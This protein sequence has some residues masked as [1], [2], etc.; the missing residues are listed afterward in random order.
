MA[1]NESLNVRKDC[2]GIGSLNENVGKD[3]LLEYFHSE[4]NAVENPVNIADVKEGAS[5]FC[6]TC[7][8]SFSFKSDNGHLILEAFS[9]EEL[10]NLLLEFQSFTFDV[11]HLYL[12]SLLDEKTQDKMQPK[13]ELSIFMKDEGAE[14]NNQFADLPAE[15][16]GTTLL[17]PETELLISMKK[18]NDSLC[19]QTNNQHM[20]RLSEFD[21]EIYNY[22]K[23]KVHEEEFLF[24]FEN[25]EI[26][27]QHVNCP[28]EALK[29]ISFDQQERAVAKF[30]VYFQ[31]EDVSQTSPSD[32]N[33]ILHGD[34]T[35]MPL[36]K[37]TLTELLVETKKYEA[38]LQSSNDSANALGNVILNE[39]EEIIGTF[40]SSL[41]I[42]QFFEDTSGTCSNQFQN[43]ASIDSFSFHPSMH[44]VAD[45]DCESNV[46]RYDDIWEKE[47]DEF[48]GILDDL[49]VLERDQENRYSKADPMLDEASLWL[50]VDHDHVQELNLHSTISK[51]CI[52]SFCELPTLYA[53]QPGVESTL[54]NV[55]DHVSSEVEYYDELWLFGKECWISMC[56]YIVNSKFGIERVDNEKW[57]G[58][59]P[60]RYDLLVQKG[61]YFSQLVNGFA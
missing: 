30:L 35:K 9:Y 20:Q 4:N 42:D 44:H 61:S 48:C 13:E 11:D 53:F 3:P 51:C 17:N 12:K 27:T 56:M 59:V 25:A 34:E 1:E 55:K 38:D 2:E 43:E 52:S 10:D 22:D 39:E 28:A 7:S 60:F 15:V 45:S 32:A 16:W 26:S 24:H 57:F 40:L 33:S 14:I 47:R 37:D 46:E 29:E 18:E 49:L 19:L 21:D 5:I 54:G 31:P 58:V 8:K 36:E 41:M 50:Q 6:S 23:V